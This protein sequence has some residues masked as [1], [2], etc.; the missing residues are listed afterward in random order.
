MAIKQ[1][2]FDYIRKL[3]L[4]KSAIV[5]EPGKEYLVESRMLP[6]LN[7]EK[8]SS[9]EDLVKGLR[10]SSANGL[11]DKVVDALTTNETSFFRDIH[12]F[13]TLKKVVLPDII[14]KR[15]SKREVNIWCGAS[16]SGQEPYTIALVLKNDFPQLN[17]WKIKFMASDISDEM[18]N[19][20]KRGA[21]TQLEVNRGLPAPMLVKHFVRQGME[22]VIKED[23]RKLIDFQKINLSKPFPLL[24]KFDIIFLRNVLIYFDVEMKKKI[25]SQ[26][27][28]V[29]RPDGYLFLGAAESTLNLDNS[30]ERIQIQQ[31]G[32]YKIRGV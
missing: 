21:F 1:G 25:L 12:P 18:L 30:F 14:E 8:F 27:R 7:Q 26:L 32:C 29:L 20:C 16:S 17:T 10:A 15:S 24:P 11:Q 28:N 2:D 13:E 31:S 19:R 22:W 5:L 6:L 4:E 9:I 23:F 3:V